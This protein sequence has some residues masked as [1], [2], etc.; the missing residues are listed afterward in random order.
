M[1]GILFKK[2]NYDKAVVTDL[3]YA[4]KGAG[5]LYTDTELKIAAAPDGDSY[6]WSDEQIFYQGRKVSEA[7]ALDYKTYRLSGQTED[8]VGSGCGVY[9]NNNN[10]TL[11]GDVTALSALFYCSFQNAFLF[12]D[13]LYNLALLLR[14]L[15]CPVKRNEAS[16]AALFFADMVFGNETVIENVFRLG[17]GEN[18]IVNSHG[19]KKSTA[20]TKIDSYSVK[21]SEDY[22][23]M[24]LKFVQRLDNILET[25][26]KSDSEAGAKSLLTLSGGLDTRFILGRM[27]GLTDT[28]QI[29]TWTVSEDGSLDEIIAKQISK[30][31]GL[32]NTY[33]SLNNGVAL[34]E[35]D[36]LRLTRLN[37]Y[38]TNALFSILDYPVRNTD[39]SGVNTVYL[40]AGGTE[41][42][43]GFLPKRTTIMTYQYHVKRSQFPQYDESFLSAKERAT[44]CAQQ[45]FHGTVNNANW[46]LINCF[47]NSWIMAEHRIFKSY[48]LSTCLPF[49]DHELQKIACAMR[50][51]WE[52]KYRLVR[53]SAPDVGILKPLQKLEGPF[54]FLFPTERLEYIKLQNRFIPG[55]MNYKCDRNDGCSVRSSSILYDYRYMFNTVYY[56]LKTRVLG[57]PPKYPHWTPIEDWF[58]E[59][60]IQARLDSLLLGSK[61]PYVASYNPNKQYRAKEYMNLV[62]MALIEQD[63]L[64]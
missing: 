18:V 22:D 7:N 12:S 51:Y 40:G 25:H 3:P 5:S 11:L 26:V 9:F 2:K 19:V 10:L 34:K 14:K 13:S 20:V 4:Y 42:M 50:G 24:S 30:D 57:L 46:Q 39:F 49:F 1:L 23:D 53:W 27:L 54:A 6:F 36:A 33:L 58:R 60:S 45:Y 29:V 28:S 35:M 32:R 63:L 38:S 59:A 48:G 37:N 41:L 16:L 43:Y 61:F 55:L 47:Q 17:R 62:T 15:K 52:N 8:I 56:L 64:T 44:S 31:L 21:T